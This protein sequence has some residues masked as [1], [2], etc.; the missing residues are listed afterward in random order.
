MRLSG[1]KIPCTFL[2]GTYPRG[3][4]QGRGDKSNGHQT[5]PTTP[6]GIH[7]ASLS[8][9]C[10]V[11]SKPGHSISACLF[12]CRLRFYSCLQPVVQPY[13]ISSLGGEKQYENHQCQQQCPVRT[14]QLFHA[15]RGYLY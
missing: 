6:G 4:L 5:C 10:P 7:N 11:P 15:R 3:A 2:P 1:K 8:F 9:L 12:A 13:G 14:R